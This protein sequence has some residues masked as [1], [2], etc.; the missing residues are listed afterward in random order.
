MM[1]CLRLAVDDCPWSP[2]KSETVDTAY[3]KLGSAWEE[4]NR[5]VVVI[6]DTNTIQLEKRVRQRTAD[7]IKSRC[8]VMS[9]QG[10]VVKLMDPLKSASTTK[11]SGWVSITSTDKS[12]I[13]I[14]LEGLV[15]SDGFAFPDSGLHGFGRC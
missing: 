4:M 1:W 12:S 15:P 5:T 2:G 14:G 10:H 7:L 6:L 3:R 8:E 13:A 9:I 11:I